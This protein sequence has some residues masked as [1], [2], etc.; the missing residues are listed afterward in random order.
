[1]GRAR[2]LASAGAVAIAA[3]IL[4]ITAAWACV[5]GPAINLST[6]E[7]KAGQEV[8][9]KGASFRLTDDVLVRFNALDGPLLTTIKP[10]GG[11]IEGTFTVPAGTKAGTYIIMAMQNDAN[12]KLSLAPIR[13]TLN[14]IGDGGTPPVLG[15]T[16]AVEERTPGLVLDNDSISGG[17]L[18]LIALGVGGIGMFLAGMAALFAG[19]KGAVPSAATVGR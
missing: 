12:G 1:M 6:I 3:S 2:R 15:A 8:G 18:A 5:S 9:I 11:N 16:T 7:A 13:T 10:V 14:V 4:S 19:R 17:T